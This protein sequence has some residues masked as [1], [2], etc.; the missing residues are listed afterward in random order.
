MKGDALAQSQGVGETIVTYA[1]AGGEPPFQRQRVGVHLQQAIVERA[2]AGIQ[3]HPGVGDL[4]I[5]GLGRAF[6]TV[7]ESR[8]G[9][10]VLFLTTGNQ[11][12]QSKQQGF[13]HS[14]CRT[15]FLYKCAGIGAGELQESA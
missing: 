11:H 13:E 8:P 5:E 15:M 12:Q 2:G 9:R 3:G 10:V 1:P 7:D 14:H 4:G 6:R